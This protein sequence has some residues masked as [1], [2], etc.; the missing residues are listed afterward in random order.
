MR[1]VV[2]LGGNALLRRGELPTEAA[3]RA[4][5]SAAAAITAVLAH[6]HEVI[7]THGNGPQVGLLALEA[8][9]YGEIEAYGLDVL[10]AES[11]AM[12][13][14]LLETALR[15]H[16]P[17]R[18]IATVLTQ[19]EVAPTDPALTAP[20]KFIGPVYTQPH[21]ERLRLARGWDV[22][23]DG[24]H[25]RRVV[26][27]PTPQR[28]LQMETIDRLVS[29]G[30]L[31][32][33]GGGGGVPVTIAA[34][35]TVSGVEGVVDKDLTAALIAHHLRADALL[36]LT[37]VPAVATDWGTPRARNIRAAPPGVLRAQ[38]FAPGSMGP[39]VEAAC[40]FVE[41]GGGLA[42]I[43]ALADASLLLRGEAGTTVRADI[44]QLTWWEWD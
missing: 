30:A 9:A 12:I 24:P 20:T 25:W 22:A 32:I 17:A 35:G 19:V 23:P 39:K 31:V 16:L 43:G 40:R 26:P 44:P 28:V 33:C 6:D 18:E 3:Q 38:R 41:G 13:G 7:L 27:S 14:Y 5:V 42:A 37:D 36:L 11:Q 4:R 15:S 8:E 29:A 2:A 10:N 21:A 34:D 1:V